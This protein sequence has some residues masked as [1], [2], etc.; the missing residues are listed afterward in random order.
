MPCFTAHPIWKQCDV[1]SLFFKITFHLASRF[2]EQ[3][4]GKLGGWEY[5]TR[6]KRINYFAAKFFFPHSV[7]AKMSK[8]SRQNNLNV[9]IWRPTFSRFVYIV[10]V[11]SILIISNWTITHGRCLKKKK[12]SAGKTSGFACRNNH[13]VFV[14][15]FFPYRFLQKLMTRPCTLF[16]RWRKRLTHTHVSCTLSAVYLNSLT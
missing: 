12:K 16:V 9:V 3:R 7:C 2:P 10:R 8:T 13:P 5:W 1:L 11:W 15:T 4:D 6:L 14:F